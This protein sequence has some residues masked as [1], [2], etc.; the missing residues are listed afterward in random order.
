[1]SDVTGEV[2]REYEKAA[3]AIVERVASAYDGKSLP[4]GL[5]SDFAD[6]IAWQLAQRGR[7]SAQGGWVAVKA[8]L[9]RT[10]CNCESLHDVP[11]T[12]AEVMAMV[13]Q[14]EGLLPPPPSDPS[15]GGE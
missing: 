13:D 11:W 14:I 3:A 4:A 8:Y 12:T 5:L 10:R 2:T 9:E 7:E 6:A 1:M 15:K